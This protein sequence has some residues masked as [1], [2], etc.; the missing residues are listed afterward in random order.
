MHEH[1]KVSV[2]SR[3]SSWGNRVA[4]ELGGRKEA[5]VILGAWMVF[6]A[7]HIVNTLSRPPDDG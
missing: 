5:V 7:Y 3:A 4:E 6:G 1:G 2:L